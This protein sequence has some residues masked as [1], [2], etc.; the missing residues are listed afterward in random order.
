[1]N[2]KTIFQKIVTLGAALGRNFIPLG[3]VWLAGNTSETGMIL[4][5]LETFLAVLLAAL[6]V[7]FRA[8]AHDPAYQTV[9]SS[10]MRIVSNGR[11]S[12]RY[13]SG[14]RRS[15]LQGFLIFSAGFGL[16]P[17]LFFV[18]WLF[19]LRTDISIPSIL[20]GLG[21][22]AFFQ[23]VNFIADF[24][25]LGALTPEDAGNY[26]NQRMGR[27]ALVYTA[28]FIGLLLG[29]LFSIEW[30]IYPFA[31]LKI[32]QEIAFIFQRQPSVTAG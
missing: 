20:V 16:I 24:F 1:M 17:A 13:D 27:V 2:F 21:G 18:L 15:L 6:Y 32:I 4:Y 19:L 5:L 28:V 29:L 11:V 12:T 23:L 30:F 14:S 8:P 31:V 7:R 10:K 3:A 9:A 26:L 22:I 25:L